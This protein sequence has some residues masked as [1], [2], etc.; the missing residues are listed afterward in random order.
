[1]S[2]VPLEIE[3]VGFLARAAFLVRAA[4]AQAL[5]RQLGD[6]FARRRARRN[7]IADDLRYHRQT[8]ALSAQ[9]AGDGGAALLT[10]T[11]PFVT[12]SLTVGTFF[13]PQSLPRNNAGFCV[14]PFT[15]RASDV[16]AAVRTVQPLI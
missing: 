14:P 11:I 7:F 6:H 9:R 13:H 2:G 16:L 3:V 1:M 12:D 8:H 5:A 15:S 10:V 4:R